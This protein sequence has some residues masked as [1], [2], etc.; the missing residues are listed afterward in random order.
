[1]KMARKNNEG[2]GAVGDVRNNRY[3]A[4]GALSVAGLV[5]LTNI[6]FT[7]S[8]NKARDA[9]REAANNILREQVLTQFI[10]A[11]GDPTP[12]FR[13][14]AKRA[15]YENTPCERIEEAHKL[16]AEKQLFFRQCHYLKKQVSELLHD[17]K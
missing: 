6:Y 7:V 16:I 2:G 15:V 1:M 13:I 4:L 3:K 9:E 5:V 12:L 17:L 11:H 8:N 14:A 10:E